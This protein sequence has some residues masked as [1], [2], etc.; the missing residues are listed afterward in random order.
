MTPLTSFDKI[1]LSLR[2][3]LL[4]RAEEDRGWFKC[5]E[6]MEY[7]EAFHTGYR[8][9]GVTPEFQHQLEI[10][11]YLRTL[12]RSLRYPK[13]TIQ[14]ALLHDVAEDY[15]V[16]F[17]ELASLFGNMVTDSVRLLTKKH[18][19]IEIPAEIYVPGLAKDPIG[20]PVK[21]AD[22]IN[23][24]GSMLG[25]F[26]LEK[27]KR[28]CEESQ[29]LHLPML[30]VARRNH[31]DQEP[32]YENIKLMLKSQLALLTASHAALAAA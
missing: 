2:Y 7:A 19:G 18:R 27:Q 6:A 5:V 16:G 29:T 28:Y 24:L 13:E 15:D 14:A 21:G 25:V 3:W 22:R 10:A 17:E 11:Q 9:D 1:R 32:L 26:S 8:K 4:G 30:K 20:A 31:P 23:N 12:H